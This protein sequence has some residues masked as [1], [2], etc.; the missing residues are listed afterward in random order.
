MSD[1]CGTCRHWKEAIVAKWEVD[2]IGTCEREDWVIKGL[3]PESEVYWR[4]THYR[5]VLSAD[6]PAPPC[7]EAKAKRAILLMKNTGYFVEQEGFEYKFK[8]LDDIKKGEEVII[9]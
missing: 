5:H 6:H 7:H 2:T 1:T 9:T 4:E 3:M 8:A